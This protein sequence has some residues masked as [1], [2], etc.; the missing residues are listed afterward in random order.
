[1]EVDAGS[2]DV[3]AA[4]SGVEGAPNEQLQQQGSNDHNDDEAFDGDGE[5]KVR[6]HHFDKNIYTFSASAGRALQQQQQQNADNIK[7]LVYVHVTLV[8]CN[9]VSD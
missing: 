1:M 4:S 3:A 8:W 2:G 9:K 5:G 7:N 6:P